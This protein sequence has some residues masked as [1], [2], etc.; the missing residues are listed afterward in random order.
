MLVSYP[1][2]LGSSNENEGFCHVGLGNAVTWGVG[3]KVWYCFGIERCTG[4]GCRE[5]SILA[6]KAVA[7]QLDLVKVWGFARNGPW[8]FGNF[9][10]VL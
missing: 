9:A 6:G 7:M 5:M 2:D 8:T 4:E 10:S 3:E 1:C